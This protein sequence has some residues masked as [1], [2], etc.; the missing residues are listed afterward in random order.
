[1]LKSRTLKGTTRIKV[2]NMMRMRDMILTVLRFFELNKI[3]RIEGTIIHTK[4][5]LQAITRPERIPGIK[6]L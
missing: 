6:T 3:I 2:K 4:L 1:V 5:Y